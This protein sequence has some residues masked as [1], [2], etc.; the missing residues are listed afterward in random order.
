MIAY[1]PQNVIRYQLYRF[2]EPYA[3]WGY[4]EQQ[5]IDREV[6]HR[7]RPWWWLRLLGWRVGRA[8]D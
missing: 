3:S 1:S 2:G 4:T 5:V 8:I 7:K 6:E